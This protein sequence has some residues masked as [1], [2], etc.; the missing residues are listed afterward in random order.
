MS[1]LPQEAARPA[2]EA[3]RELASQ[4]RVDSIRSVASAGSGH[5][6]SS[7]SAAD[8]MAVLFARHLH[9]DWNRPDRDDNDHLI[10]SKGHASPLLYALY[11]AVG[12]I[13]DRQ[14][15][16]TYRRAGSASPGP[17][18]AGPAL[19]GRGDRVA[20]P[21]PARRRR[22][23][24]GRQAA[25]QDRL[26]RVGALRRQRDGRGLHLGGPRQGVP[27]RPRQPL[28]DRRR[29]PAR[30]GGTHRA[31][32]G[33]GGLPA[34]RG[35]VRLPRR[36]HRR[37]R[38]R[39]D[40]RRVLTRGALA[41]A[42]GDPREDRQGQ[43]RARGRGHPRLARQAA[44]GGRRRGGR[45]GARRRERAQ[46]RDAAAAV[47]AGGGRPAGAPPRHPAQVRDGHEGRDARRL[48]RRPRRAR[49]PAGGRGHRRRGGQLHLHGEVPRRV[50]RAL[51]PDVHLGAADDR[52]RPWA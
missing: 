33:H 3:V 43:G 26:P 47:A 38:P 18:D 6:T 5:P 51:L 31:R 30:A 1:A 48:R 4:L 49:R 8:L 39:A 40:R 17:P 41:A 37:A 2:L 42:D 44:Q 34:A 10:F 45:A 23:R 50:P 52:L 13:D 35:G 29:E 28:G 25:R 46:G 7:L 32:V 27:L 22:G 12:V 20:G 19:G 16:E 14:L 24:A 15:I 11:K 36:R 21:G 9:Y